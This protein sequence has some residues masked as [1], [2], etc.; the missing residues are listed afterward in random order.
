MDPYQLDPLTIGY[1]Q[2]YLL[3]EESIFPEGLKRQK[4]R[5]PMRELETLV[6]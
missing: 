2:P 4:N 5:V 3:I 1:F 6:G